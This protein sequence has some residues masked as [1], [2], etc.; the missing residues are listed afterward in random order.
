MSK[1]DL[2]VLLAI[3]GVIAGAI[4][5]L[6]GCKTMGLQQERDNN[7]EMRGIY[8]LFHPTFKLPDSEWE[9]KI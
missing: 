7:V 4:L 2:L 1:T 3:A 9:G 8:A 5:S 6:S